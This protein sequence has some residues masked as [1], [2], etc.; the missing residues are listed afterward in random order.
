MLTLLQSF[1]TE[2]ISLLAEMILIAIFALFFMK[3]T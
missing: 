3:D 2:E 1:T